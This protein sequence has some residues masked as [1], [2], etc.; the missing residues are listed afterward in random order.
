MRHPIS[1]PAL[2]L[3]G[4]L[5]AG[6]AHAQ[7]KWRDADGRVHYSDQPPPSSV[8]ASQVTNLTRAGVLQPPPPPPA[9]SGAQAG[10][11]GAPTPA[12]QDAAPAQKS[13]ADRAMELRR[14]QAEREAAERKAQ[15]QAQAAADLSRFCEG[16]RA[17]LRAFES[18]MR[19]ARIN[20]AGEREFMDDAERAKRVELL[21]REI[22]S[23]C[24]AS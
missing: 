22:R 8:P 12:G 23:R 6:L 2:L 20:S 11:D 4:L 5:A 18:G 16:A 7:W 15:D 1:V 19:I 10:G 24:P 17:D 14:R 9:A 13:W 3:A 21:Q